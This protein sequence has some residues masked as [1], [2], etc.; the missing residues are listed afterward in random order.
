MQIVANKYLECKRIFIL[1]KC[2]GF[3]EKKNYQVK[4]FEK[5]LNTFGNAFWRTQTEIEL[6][7]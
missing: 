1:Y 5:K 2:E 7:K 4:L 3:K 6:I